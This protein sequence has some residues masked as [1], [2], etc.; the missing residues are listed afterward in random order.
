MQLDQNRIAIRER[1]DL[2]ILDLALARDPP[3]PGRWPAA[4][5]VGAVPAMLLN[6][7]LV[8]GVLDLDP[9]TNVARAT[10]C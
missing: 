3:M 5:A 4:L 10:C 6:A 1:G 2:E 8:P 7:W 9:E